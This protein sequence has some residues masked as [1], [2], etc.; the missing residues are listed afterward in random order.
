MCAFSHT[1]PLN[2]LRCQEFNPTETQFFH[3]HQQ[4][5]AKDDRNR[6]GKPKAV[7]R[8]TVWGDSEKISKGANGIPPLIIFYQEI[9]K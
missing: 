3:K 8:F 4:T 9:E 2:P 7:Y 6:L 5:R 1:S